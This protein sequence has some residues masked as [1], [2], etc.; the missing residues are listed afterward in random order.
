MQ[1]SIFG[2]F[3]YGMVLFFEILLC[4]NMFQMSLQQTYLYSL[5]FLKCPRCRQGDLLESNPYRIAKMNKVQKQCSS[6]AL[7][8]AIEPS[9]FT[10]SMYVSYAVGVA[11]AIATYVLTLVIGWTLGPAEILLSIISVLVVL[12]PYI[13]AVSKSIWAHFF[14]KYEPKFANKNKSL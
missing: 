11:V 6:C 5:L 9:F 10:G 13:G 4:Q 12:M 14:F 8:Y 3:C 1:K 7:K 2:N